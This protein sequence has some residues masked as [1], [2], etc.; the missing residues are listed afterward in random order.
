[1]RSNRTASIVVSLI[2]STSI[3]WMYLFL[4]GLAARAQPASAP[5][6]DYVHAIWVVGP[7]EIIKLA[8]ADGAVVFAIPSAQDVHAVAID[9]HRGVLWAYG[10]ST[11]Q[12]YSFSGTFVR[13]VPLS[14]PDGPSA[15]AV[16]S[17]D[18]TVWLGVNRALLHLDTQG[19]VLRTIPLAESVQALALDTTAARLWVSTKKPSAPTTMLAVWCP[20][21]NSTKALTSRISLLI[22]LLMPSGSRCR[23]PCASMMPMVSCSGKSP[24]INYNTS[25]VMG[26]VGC[27]SRLTRTCSGWIR[28]AGG[29]SPCS[30]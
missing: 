7:D 4:S 1:M 30:R 14:Q 17:D 9:T 24:S 5:R 20:A 27:G 25:P 12:A 2:V 21:Y 13:S 11:L 6:S 15:L 28:P 23:R 8:S 22:A 3:L 18:G 29:C 19:H 10:D 26:R 16:N